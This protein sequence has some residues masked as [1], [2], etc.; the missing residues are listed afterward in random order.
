MSTGNFPRIALCSAFLFTVAFSP[1]VFSG[2]EEEKIISKIDQMKSSVTK[3]EVSQRRLYREVL[4]SDREIKRISEERSKIN[5]KVLGSEADSQ[6][7]AYEVREWEAKV[8]KQRRRIAKSVAHMYQLK[9]P[10]LFS[11]LFSDQSASEIE[12]NVRFL[13]RISQRDFQR[14]R[15]Y[16]QSLRKVKEARENLK[17]EVRRLLTLRENLKSKEGQLL[18]NQQV[19]SQLLKKIR[20]NKEK[21]M[22]LIKKLRSRLPELDQETKVAIFEKKGRLLAPVSASPAKTYGSFF[23]PIYRVKF[24]HLGWSYENLTSTPVRA[25][26]QGQVVFV[27]SLPGFGNTLIIDHGDHYY[28]VYGNNDKLMAFEGEQVFEGQTIAKSGS[29]L[30][31]ELRHF[32]NAIDPEKWITK[33]NHNQVAQNSM[34]INGDKL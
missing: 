3:A 12:K 19:M 5:E 21:N 20:N 17:K 1:S 2:E 28:S 24:L 15:S 18:K 13:S 30:Y 23:D 14:F 16:Q 34:N 27:G 29:K 22:E 7:L 6:E 31:F 26:F 10:S 8:K 32:S 33:D 25:V 11:F 9:N 4:A